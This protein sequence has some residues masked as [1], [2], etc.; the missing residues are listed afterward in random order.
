MGRDQEG[1]S[2]WAIP[3]AQLGHGSEAVVRLHPRNTSRLFETW[4]YRHQDPLLLPSLESHPST[5]GGRSR[6]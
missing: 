2:T 5:N 6:R 4:R 3:L 1:H